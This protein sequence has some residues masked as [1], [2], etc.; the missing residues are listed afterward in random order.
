MRNIAIAQIQVTFRNIVKNY[1]NMVDMIQCAREK[2]TTIIV[3]PSYS[4]SGELQRENSKEIDPEYLEYVHKIALLSKDIDILWSDISKHGTSIYLAT[5]GELHEYSTIPSVVE[6]Q[7]EKVLVTNTLNH[8][9]GYDHIFHLANDPWQYDSVKSIPKYAT[10]VYVNGVG[11]YNIG[12]NVYVF[13]G[14]SYLS[15]DG[16]IVVQCNDAFRSDLKVYSGS[17]DISKRCSHKLL[18][19]LLYGIREFDSQVFSWHPKWII[20]LSGGL[21]ST[22]NAALLVLALGQDRVIGYNL[23]TRYNSISTKENAR[24]LARKLGI[25]FSEGSIE[26]LVEATK[27]T[28]KDF[29]YT[30]EI[31]TSIQENIQARIRGH[32]LSTF[33]AMHNGVICNNGNKVEIALGYCTLYGDTIGALSPLGDLYKSDLFELAKQINA[34]YKEAIIPS[35]LLPVVGESIQWE[36]PPSAEL[37]EGQRDP[38]KWFYHDAMI[39]HILTHGV[40]HYVEAYVEGRLMS[41]PIFRKWLSYY[42]LDS[43]PEAF[44]TDLEWVVRM[45]HI[46]TFKRIQLPP[47]ITLRTNAYGITREFQ[48]ILQYSKRY[49]EL[50]QRRV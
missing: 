47:M 2:R 19:A 9:E 32:M 31:P 4:L 21:D 11:A 46:T 24:E 13:D 7:G 16:E 48:G 42:G 37:K 23:A 35:N 41:D 44:F 28:I 29:G 10:Y 3:F 34:V 40:E 8:V 18:E 17:K 33:A 36:V 22:I 6:I 14:D 39:D 30:Q 45:M 43:D 38:M 15:V 1:T 5:N 12:K 26:K 27:D 50:K 25:Q 20:G 49:Q